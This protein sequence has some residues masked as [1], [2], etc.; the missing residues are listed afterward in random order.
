[1]GGQFRRMLHLHAA[2]AG[3]RSILTV[4]SAAWSCIWTAARLERN[5][6]AVAVHDQDGEKEEQ[7]KH[8]DPQCKSTSDC[9]III[10]KS[11]DG[12][13]SCVRLKRRYQE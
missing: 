13:M 5:S 7:L 10:T 3:S 11:G 4:G 2:P 12:M 9:C 1:M 6:R 8:N